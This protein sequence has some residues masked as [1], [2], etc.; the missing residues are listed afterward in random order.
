MQGKESNT[1]KP[2]LRVSIAF[3]F[4]LYLLVLPVYAVKVS[5]A[6]NHISIDAVLLLI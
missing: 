2:F 1:N 5:R 4:L 6:G 3:C